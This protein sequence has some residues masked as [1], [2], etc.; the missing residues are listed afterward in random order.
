MPFVLPSVDEA[1]R[2]SNPHGCQGYTLYGADCTSTPHWTV[3]FK[4]CGTF[5]E[6]KLCERNHPVLWW[7][8][9]VSPPR[10]CSTC[11]GRC[12][13]TALQRAWASVKVSYSVRIYTVPNQEM[14]DWG[15]STNDR[16]VQC[17]MFIG[18]NRVDSYFLVD[19]RLDNHNSAR[20]NLGEQYRESVSTFTGTPA[21]LY[22]ERRWLTLSGAACVAS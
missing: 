17:Y 3:G 20:G 19:R 10:L 21:V 8:T 16:I 22:C 6:D 1:V 9:F 14:D 15:M 13:N 7:G 2:R 4:T 12:A 11:E 18:F 5:R